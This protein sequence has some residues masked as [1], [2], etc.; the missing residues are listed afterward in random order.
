MNTC[1]FLQRLDVYQTLINKMLK[2]GDSEGW[3]LPSYKDIA[4]ELHVENEEVIVDLIEIMALTDG[5]IEGTTKN[6]NRVFRP[7]YDD[8]YAN[9][10]MIDAAFYLFLNDI[11][12]LNDVWDIPSFLGISIWSV[13]IA[14]LCIVEDAEL[15]KDR[16]ERM[17]ARMIMYAI[18][19]PN[20]KGIL[21]DFCNNHPSNIDFDILKI[22]LN[23]LETMN[24]M[25]H[26]IE[27]TDK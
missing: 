6:G 27:N 4:T 19:Y 18:T 25:M 2:E 5:I 26:K 3:Y 22:V 1:A 17:Y 14:N 16:E 15:I 12:A 11:E 23:N 20:F 7:L 24:T 21:D 9:G 8:I 10:P 13:N